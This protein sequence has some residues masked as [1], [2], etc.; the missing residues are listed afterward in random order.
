[1]TVRLV[2]GES[3]NARDNRTLAILKVSDASCS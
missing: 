3:P 1:M 2:E